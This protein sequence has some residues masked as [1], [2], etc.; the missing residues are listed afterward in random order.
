MGTSV[1]TELCVCAKIDCDTSEGEHPCPSAYPPSPMT[2]ILVYKM[3]T[4][5]YM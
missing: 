3:Y 4:A 5:W 2:M 1:L